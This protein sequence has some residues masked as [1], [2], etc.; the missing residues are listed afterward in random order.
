MF[1]KTIIYCGQVLIVSSCIN[2]VYRGIRNEGFIFSYSNIKAW[3]KGH[4]R[5]KEV[6]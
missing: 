3:I 2:E 6:V 4:I 1:L 5:R